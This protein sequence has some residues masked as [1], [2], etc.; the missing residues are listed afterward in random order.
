[1]A[2]CLGTVAETVGDKCQGLRH[3][4]KITMKPNCM[5]QQ[6]QQKNKKI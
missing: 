5:K 6:Q 4:K 2:N 1:M 3:K